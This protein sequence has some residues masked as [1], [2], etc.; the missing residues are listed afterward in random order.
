MSNFILI[1]A[2]EAVVALRLII[3]L[4]AVFTAL[5]LCC[6]VRIGRRRDAPAD[7]FSIP[8]GEM[9]S[10][11]RDWRPQRSSTELGTGFSERELRNITRRLPPDHPL[12]RSPYARPLSQYP[13][14]AGVALR[15][16]EAGSDGSFIPSD[17]AAARISWWRQRH[18]G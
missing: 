16:V 15:T 1:P 8:F 13:S 7:P 4:F 2:E 18:V 14:S 3:I 9:P 17:P 10:V 5:G 12:R 11:D 6:A